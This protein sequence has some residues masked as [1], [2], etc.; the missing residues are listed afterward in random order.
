MRYFFPVIKIDREFI[1]Y[2]RRC[3][4]CGRYWACEFELIG[5]CPMCAHLAVEKEKAEK[6]RLERVARA[7]R[8]AR[9][10]KRKYVGQKT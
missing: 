4:G 6:L 3:S 7:L 5:I 10:R 8:G 1:L 9:T 2:E